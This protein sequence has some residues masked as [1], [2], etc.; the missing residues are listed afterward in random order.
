MRFKTI[1]FDLDGTLTDPGLGITNSVIYALSKYGID[2]P[3]REKLYDFIGAPLRDSFARY[4]GFSEEAAEQAVSYYREYYVPHGIYE[5]EVYGGVEDLL[6]ALKAGGAA[7][8]VA[9]LKPTVFAVKVL[10]HFG[11][12]AY[13]DF[14]AGSELDGTRTEKHA[15]IEHGFSSC[16]FAA[17]ASAVMVGDRLHDIR[18]AKQAGIGSVGV[19]YGYGSRNELSAEGPDLIAETVSDL[20]SYLLA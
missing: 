19:L 15:V 12:H 8:L 14:V 6:K 1:L 16:P 10:E 7:I 20:S 9:T 17:R 4:Y 13:I 3:D 11:L 5:N 18:A 2:A